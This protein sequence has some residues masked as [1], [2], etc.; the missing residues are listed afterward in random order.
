MML[1]VQYEAIRVVKSIAGTTEELHEHPFAVSN[2]VLKANSEIISMH[3]DMKDVALAK[4]IKELEH[5]ISLVDKYEI[6]VYKHFDLILERYLGNKN[7]I[8]EVRNL[9]SEWKPIRTE[10]IE[11]MRE[12]R[13][14]EAALITKGKGAIYVKT[15]NNEMQSLIEFAQNKANEFVNYSNEQQ[16]KSKLVLYG[17]MSLVFILAIF[18][19]YFVI[20]KVNKSELELI[21]SEERW[22]FASEGNRYGVWDWDLIANEVYF[23]KQWKQMLG[24]EEDKIDNALD[25]WEKRI[26]PDDKEQVF[27][28][29]NKHLDGKTA[30]YE[31]EHRVLCKDGS[32]K[33]IMDR[34][35][36]IAW[37]EDKNPQRMICTHTDITDRKQADKIRLEKDAKLRT[38]FETIP[39]LIWLKDADGVFLDCNPKFEHLIGATKNELLGKT[40]YDYFDSVLADYFREKDKAAMAAGKPTVNEE[41]VIYADDGHQELL[42]TIKTP[43]YDSKGDLIGVLG[44]ARD[45]TEYKQSIDKLNKASRLYATLSQINAT[46][47]RERDQKKLFQEICDITIKFGKFKFAWIGLID[48]DKKFVTAVSHSGEGSNYLKGLKISLIDDVSSKGPTARSIKEGKSVVFNDLENNLEYSPWRERAM[49]YGYRSSGAFPIRV[50]NNIIGTLNVYAVDSHFFDEDETGLL[51]EM[52]LDIS[53]ALEKLEEEKNSKKAEKVLELSEQRF[54]TIFE[55]APL[56]VALIDSL[57]GHIY[58]VN[59]KFAEISGRS[60]E[61]MTSIDWMSITHPD[62]VQEDLDNMTL[63]NAGKIPGFNMQKRYMHPDGSFVWINMTIAP[64][65]V[66]D[67]KYPRHMCMIED[68]TEYKKALQSEVALG[69]IIH[70]SSNEVY[71]FDSDSLKFIEVN[72]GA[73]MNLG[74]SIDELHELTPVDLKPEFTYETFNEKLSLLKSREEEKLIFETIHKRKDGTTYPV[75][76]HLQFLTYKDKQVFVANILDIT[77]R[78]QAEER[79]SMSERRLR[80]HREQMPLGIV[81]WNTNFEFVDWNPAAGKIFGYTKEEVMGRNISETILPESAKLEVDKIWE[82][83]LSNLGVVHS[84]NENI[85]KDGT[86]ILCEWHNTTLVDKNGIVVGVTSTVEDITNKKEVEEQLHRFQKMESVGQLAGGIAHDFNNLLAIIQSNFEFLQDFNLKDD[87]FQKWINTGLRTVERGASLT[88]RLLSFSKTGTEAAKTVRINDFIDELRDLLAKSLTP[89]IKVELSLS[90]NVWYVKIDTDEF[91]NALVNMALNARDAMPDGGTLQIVTSNKQLDEHDIQFNTELEAGNYVVVSISDTGSGI[92][93]LILERV[94]EPFFTTKESGKGTGLGLSMV[95]G[96][97]KRSHGFVRFYSEVGLGTTVRLYLP[98]VDMR[99]EE[100]EKSEADAKELPGGTELIL[101]VDDEADI[102]QGLQQR[103]VSLGYQ[104][105]TAANGIEALEVINIHK[106]HIDLLLSDVVMP[107]G[108]SGHELAE[109]VE[110]REPNIKILLASGFTK[111]IANGNGAKNTNYKLLNKPYPK[112]ELAHKLRDLLDST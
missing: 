62:D 73:C 23:S 12:G 107:G 58:E 16:Y 47:I 40:D 60:I 5:A 78:H 54:K 52:V 2:A 106:G 56:G 81:E 88:R 69:Q 8:I 41:A 10:V 103:L 44:I 92:D 86:I 15:L 85:T 29:V 32:Y 98:M 63:L 13:K 19:A 102:L 66:T 6:E 20:K 95:Y 55:E 37:T 27:A 34:G 53:F 101:A 71:I 64:M 84:I 112:K 42:E 1:L 46:I 7:R 25:E 57:T 61:E 11:F 28:D 72:L 99:E 17:M 35:K 80:L 90:D 93:P 111:N 30:F 59:P 100:R 26:H 49:S 22:E 97:A 3:K 24:Y 33:W 65:K 45:I 38:L 51:E 68:I 91:Q 36:V 94:F 14:D 79:S 82:L 9:F 50:D 21:K 110:K 39:D 18:I 77:L 109:E 75:E 83:L 74:Y 31:N 105:L 67:K 108:I 76:I 48:Q 89:K 87:D 4:N 104:V 43:M 96:F 70:K